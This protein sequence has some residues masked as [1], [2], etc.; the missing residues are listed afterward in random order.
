MIN[1]VVSKCEV[2]KMNGKSKPKP[3]V[4]MP[5]A[6]EFNSVVAIDLKEI[7]NKYIL[8]MVCIF[9]RFIQGV[10]IKDRKAETIVNALHTGWCMPFQIMEENLRMTSWRSM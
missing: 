10:V 2:C 9:T 1:E 7:G 4:S 6:T 8:W 5:H 3:T